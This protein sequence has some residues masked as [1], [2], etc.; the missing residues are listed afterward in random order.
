MLDIY[1]S[2]VHSL[3]D[4]ISSWRNFQFNYRKKCNLICLNTQSVCEKFP[5][6]KNLQIVLCLIM[7]DE[8]SHL[9][10]GYDSQKQQ[11]FQ[12]SEYL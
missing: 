2:L 6:T 1:S 4:C 9:T 12:Q 7:V 8:F 3:T 10:N 5:N 11:P